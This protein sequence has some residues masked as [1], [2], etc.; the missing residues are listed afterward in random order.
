MLISVQSTRHLQIYTKN[1]LYHSHIT[2]QKRCES[3]FLG[4]G[5]PVLGSGTNKPGSQNHNAL[6]ILQYREEYRSLISLNLEFP[7]WIGRG[8][9][10]ARYMCEDN[11]QKA[12]V[13]VSSLHVFTRA[14]P[15]RVHFCPQHW[16]LCHLDFYCS[17]SSSAVTT[18]GPQ[19]QCF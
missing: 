16:L 12:V 2:K 15:T 19:W 9:T 6:N 10:T 5:H 14:Q 17:S 1:C 7:L 18:K 8:I 13:Y 3:P 11:F 4:Y